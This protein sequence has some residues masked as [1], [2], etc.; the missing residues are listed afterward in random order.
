[1]TAVAAAQATKNANHTVPPVWTPAYN[2]EQE[3]LPD[4]TGWTVLRQDRSVVFLLAPGSKW[5]QYRSVKAGEVR[6]TGSEIALKPR[7][8]AGVTELLQAHLEKDLPRVKLGGAAD[9]SG[10]LRLDANITDALTNPL[11]NVPAFAASMAPTKGRA[12]VTAWIFDAKT[13]EPVAAVEL[14][15]GDSGAEFLWGFRATG[16]LRAA[17]REQSKE[18]AQLLGQVNLAVEKLNAKAAQKK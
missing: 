8:I 5:Q 6:Y 14:A 1:M 7:E 11:V 18:L 17:L 12:N 13:G 4:T 9:A 2:A 10:V 3:K 16:R 15:N